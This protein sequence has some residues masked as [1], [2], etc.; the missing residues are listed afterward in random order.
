MSTKSKQ[1]KKG[2]QNVV[3]KVQ[4]HY[5]LRNRKELVNPLKK[6]QADAPSTS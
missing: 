3:L 2:Y 4:K 1:Y 6:A 5:N